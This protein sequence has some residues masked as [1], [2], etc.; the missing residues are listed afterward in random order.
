MK[1]YEEAIW[2]LA[3]DKAHSYYG[4]AVMPEVEGVETV[5]WIFEVSFN[6]VHKDIRKVYPA[7]C[8]KVLHG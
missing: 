5:A 3:L 7:A 4:G 2:K 8:A 1:T 6:T